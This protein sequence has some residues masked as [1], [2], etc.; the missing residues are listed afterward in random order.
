MLAPPGPH[1][2]LREVHPQPTAAQRVRLDDIV[3][4]AGQ[5]QEDG[6][7]RGDVPEHDVLLELGHPPEREE[8]VYAQPERDALAAAFGAVDG[9]FGGEEEDK[10]AGTCLI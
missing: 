9:K 6:E 4:E 3:G 8:G 2:L 7:G 10:E 5:L 1:L